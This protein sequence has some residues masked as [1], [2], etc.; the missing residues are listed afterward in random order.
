MHVREALSGGKST[1][2]FSV[3]KVSNALERAD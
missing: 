2:V 1:D 3:A